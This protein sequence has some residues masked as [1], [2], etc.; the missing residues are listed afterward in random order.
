MLDE[1]MVEAL[2][3]NLVSELG[4]DIVGLHLINLAKAA[5][6]GKISPNDNSLVKEALI[7][8]LAHTN[9]KQQGAFR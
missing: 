3:E 9:E 5:V 4:P 7:E 8:L 6:E 2:F 1:G